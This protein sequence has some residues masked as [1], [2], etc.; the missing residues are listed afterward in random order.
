[1][2]TSIVDS[3]AVHLGAGRVLA[4]AGW[5]PQPAER[6]DAGGPVRQAEFE[7]EVETLCLDA[8][9]LRN[10]RAHAGGDPARMAARIGEIVA[11][12]GKM[13][14]PETGSGGVLLGTVAAVGEQFAD[15]PA[16]GERIVTLAS[17]TL[18]PLRLEAITHVDPGSA[19]VQ[20]R[21]TAYVSASAPWGRVPD[22]LP[23][24]LALAV[25]DVYGAASHTRALAPS[26]GT[27]CVLGTGHA[28]KL[29]LAAAREAPAGTVIAVDRDAAALERVR[30]LCDV[31]VV[32][33][34]HDPLAAVAAVRTAGGPPADLTIVV[35]D[36]SGCETG[37]ILLTR[38][39]GTILFFSMATDFTTAALSADGM[40]HDVRML[41]G[42]GYTPDVGAYALD[43]VRRTP[44]L[45]AA[46]E[47]ACG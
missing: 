32:A 31:A 40:G 14:N 21:G 33:D 34:L 4:P 26:G 43:L 29:A 13:H 9:S 2:Q 12:R 35:V 47:G 7:V 20:V 25:Y 8:T 36:A 6:L 5:L 38:E 18:T 45:R 11:A 3:F 41:I 39:R 24:H 16:V 17:L 10:V 30:G 23:E 22:D 37:A 15:P 28:G 1:V 42:S 46:L 27:V 44:A 19:Q